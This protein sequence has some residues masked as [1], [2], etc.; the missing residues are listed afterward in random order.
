MRPR[1][2]PVRRDIWSNRDGAGVLEFAI[3]IPVMILFVVGI[4]EACGVL[5]AES[6]LEGGV[7]EAARYGITG[8]LP[9]SEETTREQEVVNI[10]NEHGIGFVVVTQDDVDTLVYPNFEAI[11]Q[12][13]PYSDLNGDGDYDSGEPFTDMNCNG[14]WDDD[15]GTPGLGVGGEIVLYQVAIDYTMLTG[16]LDFAFTGGSIPMRASV[17][18]RNEPYGGDPTCVPVEIT[19]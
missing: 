6:L 17:A 1:I 10:V 15:M 19:E 18:V 7:R 11:G 3:V 4:M 5:F 14:T 8:A 2:E 12:P 13:E 9:N 16:L